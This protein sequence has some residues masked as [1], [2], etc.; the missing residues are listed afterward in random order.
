MFLKTFSSKTPSFYLLEEKETNLED[1][2]R[3]QQDM[4]NKNM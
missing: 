4:A 2:F 1:V 3:K